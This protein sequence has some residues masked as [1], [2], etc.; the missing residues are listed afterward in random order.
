M[1]ATQQFS[2]TLVLK[3]PLGAFFA[4]SESAGTAAKI[5][6]ALG[7]P[8][9]LRPAGLWK[10]CETAGYAEKMHFFG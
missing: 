2:G 4:P 3:I 6:I 8:T 5:S 9:G 7:Y 10:F 1:H